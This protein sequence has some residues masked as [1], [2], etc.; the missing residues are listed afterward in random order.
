LA[1]SFEIETLKQRLKPESSAMESQGSIEPL[2]AVAVVID[3]SRN[4]GSI[5]LIRRR[6]REGDPWSGQ[7]A[8]PGGHKSPNDQT[9]LQTAVREAEEEVGIQLH[10]HSLLGALPPVYP[11]GRSVLVAPF[12]FQLR[13]EVEV[14]LN[15][16]V[17]ESFW[18]KLT[19]L[20]NIHAT[21]SPVVVQQGQLKV[22][23][24]VYDGR[25]IWGLT[26]RIINMLL[27]KS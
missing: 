13:R 18:A 22:D 26:Y 21:L 19:E 20:S 6:D 14:R 17:A 10:E 9:L 27:G 7:V 15:D 4:S 8:F 12:V 2:A 5:L 11:R 16:E 25:V 23:S 1:K 3:L 24:Y